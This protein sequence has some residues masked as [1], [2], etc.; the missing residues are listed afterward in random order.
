MNFRFKLCRNINKVL[1][2]DLFYFVQIKK[3]IEPVNMKTIGLYNGFK[4]QFVEFSS[5]SLV[6][7]IKFTEI[8]FVFQASAFV[9]SFCLSS[10][11]Y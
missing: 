4:L 10:F 8:T 11:Y 1:R 5:A 7:R 6:L 3:S 2:S 9:E